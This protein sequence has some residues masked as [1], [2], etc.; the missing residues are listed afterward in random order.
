MPGK[1]K[2][3]VFTK[4]L[5]ADGFQFS[6]VLVSFSAFSADRIFHPSF[7][8]QKYFFAFGQLILLLS[9]R[10]VVYGCN[11]PVNWIKLCFWSFASR[12]K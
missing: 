12:K 7:Q 10:K 3:K 1:G 6:N 11:A 4:R 5:L 8:I 2:I 9:G